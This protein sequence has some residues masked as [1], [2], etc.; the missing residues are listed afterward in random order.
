MRARS[1]QTSA[2]PDGTRRWP[3]WTSPPAPPSCCSMAQPTA[4]PAC[5]SARTSSGSTAPTP[6]CTWPSGVVRTPAREGP[7][8][9]VE[10]RVSV[11]RILD[12]HARHPALRGASRTTLGSS[13]PL[14]ADLDTARPAYAAHRV[15]PLRGVGVSG[16]V[17]VVTGAASGIG[18]GVARRL[19]ED[20]HARRAARSGRRR[21][22]PG[23]DMTCRPRAG[24]S[25][26]TRSTWLT[27]SP[28]SGCMP[29]CARSS[30]RS[31][32]VVTS[33]GIEAFD[34][35]LE[36][37]PEKWDRLIAVNLTGHVHL[38]AASRAGH[39][40]C[41]V[42]PHRHHLVVERTVGCAEHGAL[43]RLQGRCDRSDQ[44]ICPRTGAATASRQTPFLPPSSTHRW[45][46]RA[47]RTATC[48]PVE[49]MAKM[50]PLGR[51]GTPD[52]I[53]SACSYLCAEE[54]GYI[55]GQII[56]V[57]GGMYI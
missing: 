49:T 57:N 3:G 7:L 31:T 50:V 15:H 52:D 4:T 20:D 40:G 41:R 13:L 39:G 10:G 27:V 19:A 26:A 42:G 47:R 33:A 30:G 18:L 53:A 25:Q 34:P 46:E 12:R 1:R 17:A 38:P 37:T 23:G 44:G 54:A 8:A 14:R 16:R 56:G 21:C 2:W 9:R 5:S 24:A 35:V 45:L 32:I 36:I 6:R 48:P 55:T 43:R 22:P 28:S 51:A 29:R 11:E